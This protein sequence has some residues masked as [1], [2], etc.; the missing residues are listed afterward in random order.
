LPNLFDEETCSYFLSKVYE[1][2]NPIQRTRCLITC[3]DK[4]E[5]SNQILNEIKENLDQINK[6]FVYYNE[7]FSNHIFP[8]LKFAINHAFDCNIE[9]IIKNPLDLINKAQ[10]SK[11]KC[12]LYL[13]FITHYKQEDQKELK[14]T[15][16][17]LLLKDLDHI[18]NEFEKKEVVVKIIRTYF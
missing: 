16:Q 11:E 10:T 3:A 14:N 17:A 8:I 6:P 4:I 9:E 5:I 2:K 15:C 7:I 1:T 13:E 12:L 18:R